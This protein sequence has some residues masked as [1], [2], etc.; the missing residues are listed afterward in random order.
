MLILPLAPVKRVA[1]HGGA[2]R[3]GNDATEALALAAEE[4]IKKITLSAQKYAKHAGRKTLKAEDVLVVVKEQGIMIQLPPQKMK[5]TTGVKHGTKEVKK[6]VAAPAKEPVKESV[7][8]AAPVVKEQPKPVVKEPS[9]PPKPAAPVVKEQPKPVVKEPTAPPKPAA[10]VVKEQPK[11]VVKEPSA[12]P[13]PAAS[14]TPAPKPAAATD[15]KIPQQLSKPII[16]SSPPHM[17]GQTQ[18]KIDENEYI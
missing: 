13:Q 2:E 4:W 11:P 10:P 16:S 9:A 18:K 8:P 1:E 15:M 12:P 3:V 17:A 7:K 6:P 14:P 5:A